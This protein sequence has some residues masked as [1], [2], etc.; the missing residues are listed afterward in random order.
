MWWPFTKREPKIKHFFTKWQ[1][2]NECHCGAID[3]HSDNSDNPFCEECG[4][5]DTIENVLGRYEW[6]ADMN[7]D[8]KWFPA[9]LQRY[10][11]FADNSFNVK[12][13]KKPTGC[14]KAP[15]C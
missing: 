7:H 1:F 14:Q 12:W 11:R 15:D 4:C 2:R 3:S 5:F 13:V 6:S 8:D 10:G 9:S